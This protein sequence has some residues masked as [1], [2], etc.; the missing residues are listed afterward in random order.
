MKDDHIW[1][2]IQNSMAIEGWVIS[3]EEIGRIKT[4][5]EKSGEEE[6]V[7]AVLKEVGTNF[8]FEDFKKAWERIRAKYNNK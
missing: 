8:T 6:I 5:Y 4:E 7:D 1:K 2:E 3:D